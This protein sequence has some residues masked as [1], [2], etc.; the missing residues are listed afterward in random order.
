M[1]LF[2]LKICYSIEIGAYLA[3]TGHF[4][5]TGDKEIRRISREEL[6]HMVLIDRVLKAYKAT[7]NKL[8]NTLFLLIG[9]TVKYSCYISPKIGLNLVAS[10][11]EKF[12]V[13]S[14]NYMADKFP[15]YKDLFIEMQENEHEHEIYFA[16]LIK[17]SKHES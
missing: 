5:V 11:L 6:R 1:K 14:Y 3:Y 12:N 8:F 10:L 2:L 4:A 15:E 7:P 17:G 9:T 13:V 16:S